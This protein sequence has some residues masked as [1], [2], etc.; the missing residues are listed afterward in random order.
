[1]LSSGEEVPLCDGG[2]SIRVTKSNVE[3]FIAKV[4]QTRRDEA[5]IQVRT[6]R[7]GFLQVLENNTSILDLL[8]W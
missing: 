7:E 3:E 2:E 4:L 8:T 5:A 6:I 1:M